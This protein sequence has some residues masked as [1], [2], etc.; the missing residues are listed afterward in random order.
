MPRKFSLQK[1]TVIKVFPDMVAIFKLSAISDKS[2]RISEIR[3]LIDFCISEV[4]DSAISEFS[5]E[6]IL[7]MQSI[8]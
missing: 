6:E 3:E 5:P 8:P 7:L 4:I 2:S 1:S